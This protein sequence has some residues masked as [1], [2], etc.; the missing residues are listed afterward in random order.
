MGTATDPEGLWPWSVVIPAPEE[1][2]RRMRLNLRDA[3][4]RDG[5]AEQGGWS[6]LV[7]GIFTIICVSRSWLGERM[8]PHFGP[9]LNPIFPGPS[10]VIW[11][12]S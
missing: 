2:E 12:D 5:P 10:I 9:S 6:R 1:R 3:P 7:A 8:C 11:F 4:G